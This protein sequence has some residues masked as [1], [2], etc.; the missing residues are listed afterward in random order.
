MFGLVG[1]DLTPMRGVYVGFHTGTGVITSPGIRLSGGMQFTQEI[2][3][4]FE[5]EEHFIGALYKHVSCADLC[6]INNG[7]DYLGLEIGY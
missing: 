7:R 2:A 6:E 3:L 5:D 4:G 1:F